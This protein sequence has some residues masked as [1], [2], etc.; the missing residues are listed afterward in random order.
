[1]L[2][3]YP[4]PADLQT[5]V[6]ASDAYADLRL[7]ERAPADRPYLL[8]NMVVTADGQGRIGDN[9]AELGNQADFELFIALREQVDCV[10]AG[11]RTIDL[12]RYKGPAAKAET[13]AA[14]EER[15]LRARPLFATISRSGRLPVSAPVFQDPDI[16]IAVFSEADLV[17]GDVKAQVTQVPTHEPHAVM[18]E[19]RERFGVRTVLLEGGPHVNLPFFA[20]ELVDELFLTVA[21]LL[22]GSGDP[23]PIIAGL[24]P[25]RQ[26]LHVVG[27]LLDEDHLFLRYR[28][29]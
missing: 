11:P 14:R 1:M 9:T 24:L 13:R 26:Q 6:D 4:L 27:A 15:G 21:P 12:E 19:L 29:D 5:A 22:T 18:R 8:V 25:E 3:L 28:V 20:A 2:R 17:L 7:G 23:F 10:M 16:E